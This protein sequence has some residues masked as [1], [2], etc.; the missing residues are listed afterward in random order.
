MESHVHARLPTD[1]AH[2]DKMAGISPCVDS[3]SKSGSFQLLGRLEQ[4]WTGDLNWELFP[5]NLKEVMFSLALVYFHYQSVIE[6]MCMYVCMHR[7][8]IKWEQLS[9][10]QQ[11]LS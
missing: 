9:V 7:D 5:S 8:V 3:K 6:C 2:C 1:S 10:C 11:Q 4:C